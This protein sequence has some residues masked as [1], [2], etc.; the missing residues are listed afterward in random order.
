MCGK[1]FFGVH[2]LNRHVQA[3]HDPVPKECPVCKETVRGRMSDHMKL[4]NEEVS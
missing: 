1:A 4:H 3:F 2:E